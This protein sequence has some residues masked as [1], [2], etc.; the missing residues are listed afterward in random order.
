MW[1]VT[2][3]YRIGTRFSK[4]GWNNAAGTRRHPRSSTLAGRNRQTI[5]RDS[6]LGFPNYPAYPAATVIIRRDAMPGASMK[7]EMI[8]A[9]KVRRRL[10]ELV[11]DGQVAT[12]LGFGR[13]F[14]YR[15]GS[16]CRWRRASS[17]RRANAGP[18]SILEIRSRLTWNGRKA[19][20]IV[21]YGFGPQGLPGTVPAALRTCA[22]SSSE[23]RMTA[24]A[25]LGCPQ[26]FRRRRERRMGK[27]RAVGSVRGRNGARLQET[28]S[29]A[30][31]TVVARVRR[32]R[33]GPRPSPLHLAG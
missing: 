17:V 10:D 7:V 32:L 1:S 15:P 30:G 12:P 5:Y 14:P 20:D 23:C 8:G 21:G 29:V 16:S 6:G 9:E 28:D 25:H 3:S 13:R 4:E 11:R 31:K 2:T 18:R 24:F 26:I 19:A 27:G 33:A 22:G